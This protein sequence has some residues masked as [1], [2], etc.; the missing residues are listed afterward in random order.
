MTDGEGSDQKIQRSEPATLDITHKT[1]KHIHL[2]CFMEGPGD[3]FTEGLRTVPVR[4][5]LAS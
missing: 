4:G 2:Q 3:L 5:A 1:R